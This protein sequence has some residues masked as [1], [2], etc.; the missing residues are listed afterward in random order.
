[1]PL[2]VRGEV[3]RARGTR[4]EDDLGSGNEVFGTVLAS[5]SGGQAAALVPIAVDSITAAG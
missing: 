1:M 3:A 2:V 5:A 4:W